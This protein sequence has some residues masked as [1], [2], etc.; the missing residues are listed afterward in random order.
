MLER[1]NEFPAE[2]LHW[3][4][5]ITQIPPGS[6]VLRG[7][8]LADLIGRLSFTEMLWLVTV[9]EMPSP[10]VARVM[11][12]V[13]VSAAEGGAQSPSVLVARTVA[14]CGAPIT[15]A[16]AA[17]ALAI[18]KYHRGAVEGAMRQLVAIREEAASGGMQLD[19][20]CREAVRRRVER[21]ERLEGFGHRVHKEVDPRV[22]RL[23]DLTREA[24]FKG[25]YLDLA[26][27]VAR[28]LK[29]E[30]GKGLPVNIDGAYAAILCE[31][32]FPP[33]LSNPLF[34]FSRSIGMMAHAR[35]EQKRMRPRR[36]IHPLDWEYDRPAERG[37]SEED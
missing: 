8:P 28:A 21:K 18:S 9:G 22:D 36:Y 3:K 33:E 5:G 11:D 26:L 16:M 24:G 19:E 27:G 32:N 37:L 10:A 13:L 29:T 2:E 34:L 23:F 25:A 7:Y 14:S 17:G 1:D 30:T 31:L 4:S 15:S 20:A 6:I 12:A 35:E